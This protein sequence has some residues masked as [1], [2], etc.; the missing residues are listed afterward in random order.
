MGNTKSYLKN[1]DLICDLQKAGQA[2]LDKGHN[3]KF[4][5]NANSDEEGRKTSMIKICE[6]IRKEAQKIVDM[7]YNVK[8]ACTDDV[9]AAGYKREWP[10]RNRHEFN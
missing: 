5:P 4:V 2:L 9:K 1:Y 10:R 7:G 3:Y 8:I 6:Q